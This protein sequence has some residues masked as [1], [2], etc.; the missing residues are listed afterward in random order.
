MFDCCRFGENFTLVVG[1]DQARALY[2]NNR[3]IKG[4]TAKQLHAL[5]VLLRTPKF[6][7]TREE[8]RDE[9]WGPTVGEG[10]V[11]KALSTLWTTEPA[12]RN[13]VQT[14]RASEHAGEPR[15]YRFIGDVDCSTEAKHPFRGSRKRRPAGPAV[16]APGSETA[17][18]P[19][20]PE[21]VAAPDPPTPP[22]PPE[23]EF[24]PAAEQRP[25]K[26]PLR[27]FWGLAILL[28]V[29][30]VWLWFGREAPRLHSGGVHTVVKQSRDIRSPL[31]TD[32][33]QLYFRECV[34][35]RYQLARVSVS[36]QEQESARLLVKL[37][38][39]D[40]ADISPD[41]TELLVRDVPRFETD[42]APFFA[43]PTDGR[44]PVRLGRTVG[45]DG[46]VLFLLP[47][48]AFLWARTGIQFGA[49]WCY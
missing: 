1:S 40:I 21:K 20:P 15:A 16:V 3:L 14:V 47:C 41:G 7:C 11:D 2:R 39:P 27:W 49:G 37:A 35:G 45:L 28:L 29:F 33:T 26:P 43:V 19:E 18:T 44:D 13:L 24:Q 25:L 32:G 36:A 31:V 4:L 23:V 38:N 12:L 48:P 22:L 6:A 42:A 5:H 46:T 17:R 30:T 8:I 34:S 10:S 9:V